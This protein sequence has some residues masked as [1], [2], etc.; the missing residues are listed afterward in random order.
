MF[1]EAIMNNQTI[2]FVSWYTERENSNDGQKLQV[3]IASALHINSPKYLISAFQTNDR[4]TSNKTGNPSIFDTNHVTKYFVEVD[5]V[6]YNKD[7]DLINFAENSYLDHYR[8]LML[9]YKEYL[10]E[11]LLHPSCIL[12]GIENTLSNLLILDIRLIILTQKNS[13]F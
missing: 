8:D 4:T 7:G 6:R 2:T 3:D 9:F 10:G 13:I 1:N 11:E 5:G 12:S